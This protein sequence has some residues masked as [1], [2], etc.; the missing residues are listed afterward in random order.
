MEQESKKRFLIN[1]AFVTV[2]V[3]LVLLAS[4]ILF[5][6]LLPF[7]IG[8]ILAFVVQRPARYMASRS[9]LKAGTWAAI[10]VVV[11]YIAVVGI[12]VTVLW[13]LGV[14]AAS[15]V[16][17][18]PE[19]METIAGALNRL[20]ERI[21]SMTKQLPDSVSN[22]VITALNNAFSD[23]VSSL[24]AFFSRAAANFVGNIPA[25]FFS[26]IVTVV[27][28][29]YIAKDFERLT[30][31]FKELIRPKT[32]NTLGIIKNII[33]ESVLKMLGGYS[34]LSLITF[35]ELL[36]GFLILRVKYAVV[37][38]A[39]IAL[40]DLLPALGSGTVLL[41]WA[42]ICFI[43]GDFSRGIGLCVMYVVILVARYFAEPRI[44]GESIGVNPLLT[45]FAMFLG[46]RLGGIGGMVI[47]PIV[48]IVVIDYYKRQLNEERMSQK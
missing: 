16:T 29:C 35:V 10:L 32:F 2:S 30:K 13:K 43:S 41:P 33:V 37:I 40:I 48:C 6:Y 24:T 5:A 25:Y 14:E 12:V 19:Q 22:T 31:F 26:G 15:L 17:A 8:S 21:I 45:L 23:I 38:A 11:L 44:I 7:V 28:S 3:G 18:L 36:L 1:I 46:L 42:V 20:G 27:A 9:H 39:V 4:K 34:L 47:L